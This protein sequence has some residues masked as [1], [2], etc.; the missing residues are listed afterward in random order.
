MRAARVVAQASVLGCAWGLVSIATATEV[1]DPR[2]DQASQLIEADYGGSSGLRTA[3]RLVHESLS[4]AQTARGLTLA[5][6]IVGKQGYLVNDQF[7]PGTERAS[8]Q[9]IDRALALD[10]RYVPALSLKSESLRIAGDLEGACAVAR[11]ALGIDPTYVW[12]RLGLVECLMAKREGPTAAEELAKVVAAGPGG[13][14]GT[15]R[16]RKAYVA[17]LTM[18]AS[19]YARP[20]NVGYVR[21]IAALVDAQR[22]PQD[23]WSLG[24]VSQA[25]ARCADYD[26]AITYARKALR[27]MDYGVGHHALAVALYG[28]AAQLALAHQDNAAIVAEARAQHVPSDSLLRPF[29]WP[30]AADEV[31]R[32][33]PVV[34]TLLPR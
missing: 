27:V 26:D 10:P 13:G 30:T 15:L 31:H 22:P 19:G 6:Q 24:T 34:R 4:Q 17:A 29:E 25:L 32:L 5:A 11:Q 12:A 33:A 7:L 21:E 3:E 28:K 1:P 2:L 14:D 18:S 8:A 9:L 20:S 23:A 16:N